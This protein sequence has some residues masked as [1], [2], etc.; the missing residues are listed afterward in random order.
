MA[1][2]IGSATSRVDGR[3]KVTGEARY[4]GEFNA[5][6]L[7]YGFVIES[8]IAKGRIAR[9]DADEA[10]RVE[11]VIKVLT[12]ENRP[13]TAEPDK[14][15]K[16]DVAPEH[17]SPF[18]PL[19]D[20]SI[21][22][23]G[24]PI[25]LL[26]A[27][28]W[29]IARYAASLIRIEYEEQAFVTDLYEER[30][31]AFAVARPDKALGDAGR[32]Y[33]AAEVRHE[34]EY[35]IPTEHHNPMELFASTAVWE[36]AG[37]LTVYDKTQGVQNVQRYL[38]S[39]FNKKPEEIRVMSQYVGGAFGSGLRPQYQVVLATLG[40]LAL[41]RSVRL[42]LTRRQMYGL[43]HRPATIERVALGSRA[44]GTLDSVTHEAI[45]VTSQF[46]EFFRNDTGWAA[47]LYKSANSQYVHRLARLDVPSSCDM[48][49][50]GA[51]TGVYALESAMDELAVALKLDPIELRLRCYSDRDQN[52]DVPY[53]S[54]QLRECY[55]QGAETF[56]WAKRNPEPRSMRDGSELV[57]WGMA[58]GVWEALQVSAAARI[59]L[60]ANGHAEVS[61]AASDI[62]TGTYTIL[63]QVA[64]DALG[65]PIENISVRL[66]DSTLPQ[67]P[68]EGGSWMAA[69]ASHA[70]VAVADEVRNELLRVA[71]TIKDSP[72]SETSLENTKLV[73]GRIAS[74][75]VPNIAVS[76]SDVMRHGAVDRIEKESTNI[77]PEDN[78]HA[79]NTHSAVFAEVKVDEQLGV[80]RVTRVV[81]AVAAGRI[82]NPKTAQSQI[83]GGVV[84]G[85]GM[86]LHEK[87]LFDH[88]FG[89]VMNAN[90][91]EYHVPVNADVHDIEVIFVDE[92]D[93]IINPM[94]VKGLGEIGI[95]G[96]AAAI[97]NAVY[98]ATGTRVRDLPITLDKLGRS[99]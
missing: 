28:E 64:A 43:G 91:A 18:R 14:A 85:I 15:W 4:A 92:P 50:P 21:K 32:A 59:V 71:K 46:E 61:C 11:G 63:A 94:G 7:C 19:Y 13:R 36:G 51:A 89:R 57:G 55:R 5:P 23:S 40:A 29:E 6:D 22:F 67:A 58:T 47:L 81:N 31:R 49:A 98:H 8:T 66:G 24:Q 76:I 78:A 42:V 62:G 9:I 68:V 90:I 26:V 82:L 52:E 12:P 20:E 65:L 37:K 27:E 45:A 74:K 77:F 56:G 25:V 95:V 35:F 44:D 41:Q 84:W 79:R 80:V 97:A 16:D 83:M 48:R 2:Y 88:R 99:A 34:A 96:V 30:H 72:L 93:E 1:P 86:A 39:V 73:G 69:S 53:T 54:K 33:M 60:T 70:V 75:H 17:G 38:C 87:T 10:L 3:A